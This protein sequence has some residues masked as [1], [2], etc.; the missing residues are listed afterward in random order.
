MPDDSPGVPGDS[1]DQDQPPE[2]T[3]VTC[4]GGITLPAIGV[5]DG[6]ADDQE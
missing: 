2:D 6:P 5:S 3:E 1:Q 4:A